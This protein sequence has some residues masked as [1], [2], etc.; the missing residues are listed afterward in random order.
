MRPPKYS[1]LRFDAN[2]TVTVVLPENFT[3]PGIEGYKVEYRKADTTEWITQEFR[4]TGPKQLNDSF[5]EGM[6]YEM[7]IRLQYGGLYCKPQLFQTFTMPCRGNYL[8][9]C[10]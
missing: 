1:L 10:L 8:K 5:D 9:R 4:D 7:T 2:D 3:T 6:A